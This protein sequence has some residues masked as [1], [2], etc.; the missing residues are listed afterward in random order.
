MKKQKL[1]FLSCLILILIL[2]NVGYSK[3]TPS[4]TSQNS[5]EPLSKTR[6]AALSAVSALSPGIA[7]LS[8]TYQVKKERNADGSNNWLINYIWIFWIIAFSDF[9]LDKIPILAHVNQFIEHGIIWYVAYVATTCLNA[10]ASMILGALIG[11]GVQA[12]RHV[13]SGATDATIVGAP[14]R[15]TVEDIIAAGSTLTLV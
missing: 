3:E 15:S 7:L 10:D 11:S 13:Y 8:L 12:G 5:A 9:I 14:I 2:F 6:I 4:G 1:I